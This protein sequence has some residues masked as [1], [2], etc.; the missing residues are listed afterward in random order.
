MLALVKTQV[1]LEATAGAEE[2]VTEA[3]EVVV[4]S[5]TGT[6]VSIPAFSKAIEI[7][8][9]YLSVYHGTPVNIN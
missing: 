7:G 2:A 8:V 1:E 5:V 4:A 9:C 6:A 3:A